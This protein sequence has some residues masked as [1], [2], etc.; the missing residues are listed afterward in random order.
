MPD[1]SQL[2]SELHSSDPESRAQ[3]IERSAIAVERLIHA[4][5]AALETAGPGDKQVFEHVHRFGPT[6][7]EPVEALL[8]RSTDPGVR[9]LCALLLLG[10]HSRSGFDTLLAELDR[11]GRWSLLIIEQLVKADV[12]SAA[13]RLVHRLREV[14]LD[15]E[16]EIRALVAALDCWMHSIPADV[17]PRLQSPGASESLRALANTIIQGDTPAAADGPG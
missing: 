8:H 6:M 10:L 3:A 2:L 13:P 17:I 9:V 16:E 14:P 4:V 5:V 15:R 7:V 11:G 1:L 12:R